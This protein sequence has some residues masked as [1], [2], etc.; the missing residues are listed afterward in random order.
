M[1]CTWYYLVFTLLPVS[2]YRCEKTVRIKVQ[3][4]VGMTNKTTWKGSH[5]NITVILPKVQLTVDMT[6][7]CVQK[8][9]NLKTYLTYRFWLH[10]LSG[11]SVHTATFLLPQPPSPTFFIKCLILYSAITFSPLT[12]SY[13]LFDV[14]GFRL[15]LFF[16][17]TLERLLCCLSVWI[18]YFR[19]F[20]RWSRV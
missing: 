5:A 6:K 7:T 17:W 14:F 11:L 8:Y 9:S 18:V 13:R 20:S 15:F 4:T 10:K 3:F 2:Y 16:G 1:Q 12:L 19:W